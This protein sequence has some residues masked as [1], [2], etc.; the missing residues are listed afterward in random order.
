MQGTGD[1][2]ILLRVRSTLRYGSHRSFL[3]W[4]AFRAGSVADGVHAANL[5]AGLMEYYGG[6]VE[7]HRSSNP[8]PKWSATKCP[9]PQYS[10]L[11]RVPPVHVEADV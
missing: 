2:A 8:L 1:E 10:L 7:G 11:R 9:G 6:W 4:W 5:L 3:A